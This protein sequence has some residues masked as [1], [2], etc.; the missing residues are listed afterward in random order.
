[1]VVNK[2]RVGTRALVKK[3]GSFS[4]PSARPLVV[5]KLIASVSQDDIEAFRQ[6]SDNPVS[7]S[8]SLLNLSKINGKVVRIHPRATRLV[9][10]ITLIAAAGGPLP[11]RQISTAADNTIDQQRQAYEFFTPRFQ[12]EISLPSGKSSSLPAGT[13]AWVKAARPAECLWQL[14]KVIVIDFFSY[15]WGQVLNYNFFS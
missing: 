13:L 9:Q 12:V 10:D 14:C 2:K 5:R 4:H 15:E 7:V 3:T 6:H 11:V 8:F 1:M